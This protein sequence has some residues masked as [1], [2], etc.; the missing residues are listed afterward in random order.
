MYRVKLLFVFA[1]MQMLPA[2]CVAELPQNLD[3]VLFGLSGCVDYS[4]WVRTVGVI[5][6]RTPIG[7]F[8]EAEFSSRQERY[9]WESTHNLIRMHSILG[10]S[11]SFSNAVSSMDGKI[12]S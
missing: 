2:I 10:G 12:H 5:K 3:E 6:F 4:Q 7:I 11:E 8:K 1:I 9:E